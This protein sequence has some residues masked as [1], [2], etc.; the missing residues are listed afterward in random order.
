MFYDETPRTVP[1]IKCTTTVLLAIL[2]WSKVSPLPFPYHFFLY[3][4]DSLEQGLRKVWV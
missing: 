1:G 3:I 4:K 2:S